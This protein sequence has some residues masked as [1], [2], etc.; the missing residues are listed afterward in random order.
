MKAKIGLVFFTVLYCCSMA[1]AVN[2]TGYYNLMTVVETQG[3]FGF[4]AMTSSKTIMVLSQGALACSSSEW[5]LTFKGTNYV[6]NGTE[7]GYYNNYGWPVMQSTFT[8]KGRCVASVEDTPANLATLLENSWV[9]SPEMKGVTLE[10]GSDID[11]GEFDSSTKAGSCEVNHFPLSMMDNTSFNGN[12]FTISHLCYAAT[13]MDKP[14]GLFESASNVTIQNVKLNGVRIYIDGE[15][16]DGKDYY[17]VGAFV[18]V[19]NLATIDS[20][21]LANDSIQAPIAGGLVGLVKNSTISNISGDDDIHVSNKVSITEGY[22]GSS[23]LA[24]FNYAHQV[25]LGGIAGVAIRSERDEDPTFIDD[26][27]KVEIHDYAT[28]HRSALGGIVGFYKTNGDTLENLKVYTKYGGAGETVPTKISGGASMGGIFGVLFAP[29]DNTGSA[30]AGNFVAANCSF[31]GKIYDAASP[32]TIAVGGIVGL[33]TMESATSVRVMNSTATVDIKDSLRV[34]GVYRY[35]AGGIFGYGGSCSQGGTNGD[36]FLTV[37]GSR[38]AGSIALSASG[39][40]VEGLHSDAY[41]GGIAGSACIAQTGGLGLAND[42]SSVKITSKVKTSVDEAKM[43]NGNNARDSVFVGGMIG[44]TSVAVAKSGETLLPAT[45]MNLYYDGSIAV[46]DSLNSV[47]VGGIL[48]GFP[49]AEGGKSLVFEKVIASNENLITYKA[50]EAPSAVSLS[51]QETD[52][53][54]ICGICNEIVEMSYVGVQGNIVVTGKHAANTLYVG[55]LVGST[56]ANE[57]GTYLHNSFNVGNILVT[58]SNS[59]ASYV[60]KVGYLLG[61]ALLYKG[62]DIRSDYHYSDAAEDTYEPFGMLRDEAYT[63]DWRT[64]DSIFYVVRNGGERKYTGDHHNG[65]ELKDSMKVSKFAGFLNSAYENAEDYA[66][67]FKS[68]TN[69]N[70]PIF[71]DSKNLPVVPELGPENATY[72]VTFVDMNGVTIKQETVESGKAATAPTLEEMPEIEG[73]AFTGEWDRDFEKIMGDLT[74]KAEYAI[75][76]YKVRFFDYDGLTPLYDEQVVEYMKSATAPE[77]PTRNGYI[78][79]GWSDSSYIQVKK[80]LDIKAVYLAKKY[81]I[82]FKNFDGSVLAQDSVHFDMT[83]SEPVGI[84]RKATPE[85]SYEFK[86]WHPAITTVKGDAVYTAQYDSAKVKYSVV[87]IDYDESPIGDT[88]WVEYGAAAV[89]PEAPEHEG[90][91][92]VGWDRNFS[93]IKKNTEIMARYELVPASSASVES[94]SSETAVSSS[95]GESS[96]S[97]G[98]SSSEIVESSSSSAE[99]SSSSAESSSSRGELKLVEPKIEQSGNAVRLTFDAE[100][101]DAETVVRVVV[102][103]E[104]GIIVDTVISDDVVK[105]GTWEM[106]PAPMGKFKV[107]LTLDDQK[108][109]VAFESDFEVASEIE[110]HAESWQMVSLSA[111]DR[112]S[113]EGDDDASFYWWDERNPVGDYWQYRA[114]AGGDA[115]ATRGFWYGT[116]KGKPL[117]LRE[118]TGAKDSEIVWELD[119]LYSGWNLVANPYGWYVD[120]SKGVADDGSEVSFWRWNPVLSEYEVPTV[121][122][123]Y[124]AVWAKASH[125]MTWRVSAAPVFG[126]AESKIEPGELGEE[127][128]KKKLMKATDGR[129]PGNFAL[130]ATLSDEYGKKDSWNVFGVGKPQSLEEP[131][132]GMGNRVSLSIRDKD[133]NGAK[134]VKLAKSIKAV[135]DEYSWTLEMSAS[136]ARDGKLSFEGVQELKKLGL[137]LFVIADGKTTEVTDG[138]SVN[139]AL[140]KSASQVEVRVAASNAVV[141]TKI[142]GFKSA[143]AGNTLQLGFNAP[144]SLAGAKANYAIAG[145]DGKVVASGRFTATAGTNKLAMNVPK[146]GIYFVKIKVGAQN[147]AGKV[148]VR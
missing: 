68:G 139:V 145:I 51:V 4:P 19:L 65:T 6:S 64:S 2:G 8:K 95:S 47:F 70:L 54:G 73:Y 37:T 18:G 13:A 21:V 24:D 140:A 31:D 127:P 147:M 44:F 45:L 132:A 92:F 42:S 40:A 39:T 28:G 94:S 15:S 11:L 104:N 22:A 83:V 85:Y 67:S 142:S 50:K 69:S 81:L 102:T 129:T 33:G 125:A 71:T 78:F 35:Y 97:E 134:G 16:G 123:P 117:V 10:L 96:S 82:V 9:K 108:Q 137:K 144:E 90:Y 121:I 76:L 62:F 36:E 143:I 46:E 49:K 120:L 103:G 74:V 63:K 84:T 101:A 126:I 26:S 14:V 113:M 72:V 17:P 57:A 133:E 25:F 124:E 20:I 119:S 93:E 53:G 88:L 98:S 107:E 3:G 128:R 23:V 136:T 79:V 60:Q 141:T 115:D 38:T 114:F 87:F 122:G 27:L 118:S 55:G 80:N 146:S 77:N 12:H 131:P 148:L 30:T 112:S 130:V 34:A 66:W 106:A 89:A 48:G 99:E 29:R 7:I 110:V 41:L 5:S 1:F 43:V 100:N 105:G 56:G 116:A 86:G 109:T 52:I 91:A 32:D 111:L 138:K 135:E 75:N 59:D 58:A 61:Y